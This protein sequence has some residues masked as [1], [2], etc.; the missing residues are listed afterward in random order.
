MI[1]LA[2]VIFMIIDHIGFVFFPK[3]IYWRLF[4]RLSMPLFAYG[5][6]RGYGYSRENGTLK[7]YLANMS[8]F[9]AISQIPYYLVAGRGMNIG[10]TWILSL[11]LLIS[12]DRADE[13]CFET[14]LACLGIFSAVALLN[15]DYGVY[16]VLM[17]FAMRQQQSKSRMFFRMVILWALY[18]L[19]NDIGTG[20]VQAAACA[21]VPLLA[22]LEPIDGKIRLPRKFYYVFYP[23]HLLVLYLIKICN[24][25]G[26]LL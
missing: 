10:F 25:A 1:K 3:I 23:A 22:L 15:V 26:W 14:S 18:V 9:A 2:A 21:A 6:A 5:I 19:L 12:L 8:V 7:K 11:L 13:N 24:I 20:L 4:G 17:P 16:G